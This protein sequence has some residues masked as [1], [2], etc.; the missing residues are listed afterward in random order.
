MHS[1]FDLPRQPGILGNL[2]ARFTPADHTADRWLHAGAVVLLTALMVHAFYVLW[3][4]LFQPLLDQF[5]FRQTQT[6]ITAYW[7]W[8]GGP[9]FAYETPVLGQPWTI[10]FEFPLYQYL[11][12]SLRLAGVPIDVGG[13]LVTFGF[14]LGCLWP[15]W[16]LFRALKFG[17]TA[18]LVVSI[19]FLASP[20]YVY[21]G[22][23]VM[24]ESCALFFGL[25]WLALL[26]C[27]LANPRRS[28]LLWTIFA[29]IGGALAKSTTFPAFLVLGG[30]LVLQQLFRD[31]LSAPHRRPLILS[32]LAVAFPLI[33]GYMWVRYTDA[34]KVQSPFGALLT[35]G[36]LEELAN[37]TFGTSAQRTSS[38]FWLDVV[39]M[40]AVPEI[41]GYGFPVALA[42]AGAALASRRL[43]MPMLAAMI[44]FFVPFAVFTNLHL[45]HSYY[46]NANALFVLAA[47][48]LGV[49]SIVEAGHRLLATGIVVFLVSLQLVFFWRHEAYYL[50]NDYSNDARLQI[51]LQ[52]RRLSPPDGG[53]IVLG[54]DW[55]SEIP[56]YAERRSVAPP[57]WAPVPL[58][59]QLFA[60]PQSFLGDHPLVGV[61]YCTLR[62][63]PPQI[64]PLVKDFI[65]GRQLLG[66]SGPCE[67]FA[68][69]RG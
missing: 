5:S 59:K 42:V 29:G 32:I 19:L 30:L 15:L 43:L 41:L 66:K 44:A 50:T 65:A 10:P 61:V 11:V 39:L 1:Q 62:A 48:G 13:R 8:K 40:R 33:I 49:T 22:R 69:Q 35:S 21:W 57:Y 7:L 36:H 68:P 34:A 52:A 26:A 4:G 27:F 55:S 25:L 20:I 28:L 46:Q 53:L 24:I 47:V 31:G 14:Y 51:A 60:D 18:Y 63:A 54:N 9:W 3:I 58:L 16:L 56:Y 6:A 12:A 64:A 2:E 17:R 37:W 38:Q 45:H 67:L 23:T